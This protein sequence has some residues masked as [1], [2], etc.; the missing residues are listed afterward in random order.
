MASGH[1]TSVVVPDRPSAGQVYYDRL[2]SV[3]MR[4]EFYG[5]A[6]C[7]DL[8]I[9][10]TTAT[11]VLLRNLRLIA[12]PRRTGIDILYRTGHAA[13]M[14]RYFLEARG[15][16]R[17]GAR[18]RFDLPRMGKGS[19]SRLTLAFELRNPLFVNFTGMPPA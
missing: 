17:R 8:A 7:S 19:W 18:S 9:E 12:K 11:Q 3:T 4:H 6:E 2:M 15:R 14:L 16:R 5:G 10:P 1:A 13:A